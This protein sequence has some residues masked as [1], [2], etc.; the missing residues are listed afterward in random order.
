MKKIVLLSLAISYFSCG[1]KAEKTAVVAD[2]TVVENKI[3]EKNVEEDDEPYV[4]PGGN[5]YRSDGF[6]NGIASEWIQVK[7]GENGGN[8]QGIWYWDSN[9]A[10]I[11]RLKILE[12]E[13]LE[14]EISAVTGVLKFPNNNDTFEF[15][16]IEDRF[17]LT[18]VNENYQEFDFET[19]EL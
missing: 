10:E 9:N 7:F 18:D 15:V 5:I 11:R 4:K 8:L 1:Q 13:H 19:Y 16:I 17:G 12:E 6:H 14:G 3:E 2:A